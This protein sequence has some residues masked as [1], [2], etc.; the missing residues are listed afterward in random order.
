M[1]YADY[2]LAAATDLTRLT[3]KLA[4]CALVLVFTPVGSHA[5]GQAV[6]LAADQTEADPW[7]D[8]AAAAQLAE[9]VMDD[10]DYVYSGTFQWSCSGRIFQSAIDHPLVLGSLWAAY[11][12]APAY[13][14][15]QRDSLLHVEDP[16]GL[17]GDVLRYQRLA[18]SARYLV[19][20]K[21]DHWAVPVLNRGTA[22]FVLTWKEAAGGVAAEMEV[23]FKAESSIGSM[24]LWAVR[25]LLGKHV[26]N[27]V[28]RN[29]AD[30]GKIMAA[31]DANPKAVGG[32]LEGD[33][34]QRF[35]D[36]FVR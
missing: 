10:A 6:G 11:G 26:E 16:T 17:A 7:T 25:P 13:R 14:V 30:A 2:A 19:R 3:L 24:V 8:K 1:T 9:Q 29:L 20:G 28:T 12:Y 23:F 34:R 31:L 21:L 33:Q 36:A 32:R 18:G 22:V 15:S 5:G 35:L 4:W 27:R